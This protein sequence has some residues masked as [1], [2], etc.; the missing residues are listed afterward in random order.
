VSFVHLHTHSIYSVFDGL[1]QIKDKAG[2]GVVRT[3]AEMGMPAIALTDHKG[4]YGAVEFLK[5]CHIHGI[6][7]IIGAEMYL[8]PD[9]KVR[10]K[11]QDTWHLTLLA[12]NNTGYRSLVQLVTEAQIEHHYYVPRVDMDVL[13]RHSDGI[14]AMS[15]CLSGPL[16]SLILQGRAEEAEQ[17][18][19]Q[20]LEIFPERFFI[21]LMRH[22][23][24]G[25]QQVEPLLIDMAIRHCVPPVATNDVHY[26]TRADAA[27][28][29]AFMQS[30]TGGGKSGFDTAEFYF[31]SPEQMR[32]L[33]K[34][35]P[36]AIDN[37]LYVA[38][39][40]N[41]DLELATDS[42]GSVNLDVV[43]SHLPAPPVPQSYGGD[44]MEYL[45]DLCRAGWQCKLA[46]LQSGSEMWQVYL[47][48]INH[49]LEVVEQCGFAEYLV[50][51][52][53]VLNYCR[54]EEIL[55]GPGRGSVTGSLVSYLM[56][57]SEVDPIEH[58]LYF[59]RFLDPGRVTMPDIDV[60]LD[61]Y[62][63][64][65][66]FE[67]LC[68]TYGNEHTAQI[69][70]FRT[71]Q[72]KAAIKD[73]NRGMGD[74]FDSATVNEITKMLGSASIEDALAAALGEDTDADVD[75]ALVQRLAANP[76]LR[77]LFE[78][79][80]S[81]RG[82]ITHVSVHAAGMVVSKEPLSYFVPQ[83]KMKNSNGGETIVSQFD[84]QGVEDLG[85]LKIDLLSVRTLRAAGYCIEHIKKNHGVDLD[86]YCLPYD[87]PDALKLLQTGNSVGLFQLESRG[88]Q[89]NLRK[90]R[91]TR[92]SDI[93]ILEAL[94]RPGPMEQIPDYIA[95]RHGEPY[96]TA[97]PRLNDILGETMGLIIFQEDVIR[98]LQEVAGF[99]FTEADVCRRSIGK[100]KMEVLVE[101]EQKFLQGGL[102]RGYTQ[103]TLNNIWHTIQRFAGYGFN[104]AHATGYSMTTMRCAYLKAHYP[105]EFMC[106]ALSA[107]IGEDE[108]K[109]D[110]YVKNTMMM[111]ISI[112]PPDINCSHT[113]MSI[114]NGQIRFGLLTVSGVGLKAADEYIANRPPEGYKS[115]LD[116]V[117][118]NIAQANKG[119]V[120]SLIKAGAFDCFGHGRATLLSSMDAVF[121]IARQDAKESEQESFDMSGDS[122][123]EME[124]AVVQEPSLETLQE[125]E[126]EVMNV[127]FLQLSMQQCTRKLLDAHGAGR[128][129]DLH[130]CLCYRR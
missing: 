85:L 96:V 88:Q 43:R 49:E 50:L 12:E 106:G 41:V 30:S 130:G 99:T 36:Y 92:F 32:E 44:A 71:T 45:R 54:K 52:W 121:D 127:S 17:I 100:K 4:M 125:W 37:T 72:D 64:N 126:L 91:P 68:R 19:Q 31:K 80:K 105:V 95:R 7:P 39:L 77:R 114:E 51:V 56:G 129:M 61:D 6:K 76:S 109:F 70:T 90:L 86:W 57:I 66:G 33:F 38:G 82:L 81:L 78:E 123:A 59:E 79:A 26:L 103:Q 10:D 20:L 120:S 3:A 22:G 11:E 118:I 94:Y 2:T 13:A 112:L 18:L 128:I 15:A 16:S 87:D 62:R 116:F 24:E 74:L 97:D 29:D 104:K 113:R 21:E 63:R 119:S 89:E 14:I 48:R 84:M 60:D 53:D 9:V 111:G 107:E 23:L 93:V 67:Y 28:H 55:I 102:A 108:K 34:D 27:A 46:H 47:D 8:C 58:G 124:F 5:E 122:S 73:R 69:I 65:E 117:R 110:A 101:N 115:L 35:I 98:I 42:E 83:Q 1:T 25:E 75:P 40:C